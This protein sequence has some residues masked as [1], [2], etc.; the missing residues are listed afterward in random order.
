[1]KI[2]VTC[3][4]RDIFIVVDGAKIAKRGKPRTRHARTW[5]S[6]KPGWTVRDIAYPAQFEVSFDPEGELAH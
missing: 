3:D 1:M 5:I 6:L 2:E 4:G